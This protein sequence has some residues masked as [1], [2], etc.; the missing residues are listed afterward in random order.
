MD[1]LSALL[2]ALV[3]VSVAAATALP[4]PFR[5]DVSGRGFEEHCIKLAAGE[6]VRYRY[7]ATA[8]VD[9]NIHYHRG[10]DVFYPV[11]THGSRS[12]DA[13]FTAPQA[14]TYCL[15]WERKA[16]GAA[17]IDGAVEPVRK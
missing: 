2:I 10:N 17:R 16:D 14:E 7:T 1:R 11:K 6:Q 12:A 5:L 8:D 9:F 4:G 3:P 13:A 15:M